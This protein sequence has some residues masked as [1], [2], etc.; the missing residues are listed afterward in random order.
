MGDTRL[1]P[2][3]VIPFVDPAQQDGAEVDRPD[4][5]SYL[6]EADGELLEG[7]GDEH[8]P[9]LEPD[10][11]RIGDALDEEV[12]GILDRGFDLLPMYPVCTLE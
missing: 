10:R 3:D 8:E 2:D 12:A 5:V 7:V 1:R 9:L 6:L 4:P 11:P